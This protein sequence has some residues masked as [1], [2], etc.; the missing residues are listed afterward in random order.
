MQFES[1]EN[2]LLFDH[3][4]SESLWSHFRVEDEF[5]QTVN[6]R[7]FSLSFPFL[8]R[9]MKQWKKKTS[10]NSRKA[11]ISNAEVMQTF[12]SSKCPGMQMQGTC[13]SGWHLGNTDTHTR[14][15]NQASKG[16]EAAFPVAASATSWSAYRA[17]TSSCHSWQ[18]RIKAWKMKSMNS[19]KTCD[20]KWSNLIE[21]NCGRNQSTTAC[22]R[23]RQVWPKKSNCFVDTRKRATRL[24]AKYIVGKRRKR[25]NSSDAPCILSS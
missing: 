6:K 23:I 20:K 12:F 2:D 10:R 14:E 4:E 15:T 21:S 19:I 24:V 1:N 11:S 18:R 25:L 17:K 3:K 7:A 5:L 22:G 9:R 13:R 8:K 16:P